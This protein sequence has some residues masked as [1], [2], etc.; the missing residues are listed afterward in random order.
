ML[1][2]RHKIVFSTLSTGKMRN[3]FGDDFH[4]CMFQGVSSLLA[5]LQIVLKYYSDFQ[6]DI[7]SST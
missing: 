5:L 6:A 1:A 7:R 4:I 2:Y 3:E